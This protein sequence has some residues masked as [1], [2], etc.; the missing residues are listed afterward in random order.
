MAIRF[1]RILSS[2]KQG[3]KQQSVISKVPKGYIPVY[4]GDKADKQ[5]YM[6]PLS[7]L[8]DPRFQGLLHRVEEEFGF[9]HSMGGLTLRCTEE[10]FFHLTSQLN[11]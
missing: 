11:H 9:N 8:R 2:V 5:R 4:V 3:L 6:V 1:H 10:T 7:Y